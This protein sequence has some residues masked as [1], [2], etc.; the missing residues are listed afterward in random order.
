MKTVEFAN[1][2]VRRGRV[3]IIKGVNLKI[4][5]GEFVG[6]IGPNGAGKSTLLQAGLGLLP[7]DGSITI[8]GQNFHILGTTGR[9]R[10]IAYVAQERDV[11][12]P[13]DVEST[14]ALGRL[15]YRER[16]A[17]RDAVAIEKAMNRMAVS[18]WRN[19]SVQL[20][21]VGERARVLIAR[22]IAQET[23]FLFADEP[24]AGLDPAYQLGLMTLFKELTAEGRTVFASLHDLS[25]AAR[26]CD[27]IVLIDK[28]RIVADGSPE[29]VL[30]MATLESVYGIRAQIIRDEGGLHLLP[31]GLT[32]RSDSA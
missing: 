18:Q 29:A 4:S 10:V 32:L 3:E 1:V 22:A 14:V 9:A 27:R 11:A 8:G 20:L 24:T 2:S 15:P 30:T 19:R 21:S 13:I 6:L 23:P 17:L 31:T 28:G 26:W 5:P 25:L 12:W 16:D 7:Y